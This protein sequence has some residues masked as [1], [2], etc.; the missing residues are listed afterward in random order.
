MSWT[1]S[2]G[3]VDYFNDTVYVTEQNYWSLQQSQTF[4]L[5]R[6]TPYC[7]EGVSIAVKTV[8][9]TGC[10]F[11]VKSGGHVAFVGASN[12]QGVSGITAFPR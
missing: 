10:P 4:P 2:L 7:A 12:I 8:R 3:R 6:Y 5:C 11:A 9:S 1:P